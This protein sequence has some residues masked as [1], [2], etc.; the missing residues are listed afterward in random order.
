MSRKVVVVA[1]TAATVAAAVIIGRWMRRKE[2][3]RKQTQRI[4]RKFARECATPVSKLWTV[5][6]AMVADMAASLAATT[7]AE[8]RGSLNMLV[9][10]AG[11]LPS[12]DEKGLHYGANLRGKELLLLR[13]TLGG[14]EEPISDIYK[15]EISIPEDVL[16]G[17]FKEL[18]DFISLDLVKFLG[19]NPGEETEDV[20]NL[21]FTLTRYVE[22]IRSGSISAIHRKSLADGDDD[23]VLK[24]FVNDMNESLDRHGLKIRMNMAL[25]DDTIGILAGGRYYHKDTVAAVTL[26]MG[27][28]AAY[29]EQAQEVL[30]WKSTIPNEP[31]EIVI[32][33]EWGDFR[34]CHL[35]LTEFDAGLDAESLNPG[36]HVFEKM[37]SGGYL[38][39]IVRRVLLRM[40]EESALFGDILPPKLKTPYILGSPDMAAMHQDISEDRDIVNKKLKEVFGIMDS[41][42]AAREVVV[43]VCDVVAERAARV[44]GAGIV[45]MI[46]KLGR[47]EKKMSIVIVE[48]GL[49]DHYRVFRN[50]L[51]SSVWEMLG[52]ELSDHVVIEHSHGGSGAGALF[53]AACGNGQPLTLHLSLTVP[54]TTLPEREREIRRMA[55]A[56]I[57]SALSRA[58]ITAAPKTSLAPKRRFSSSAGLDD[59]CKLRTYP[60]MHIRNK[61]FP[62]GPDGLFEVK[63]NEGH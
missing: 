55:T 36:S 50:Y 35:P 44:A 7:A 41:T 16:N 39:D 23:K 56:I 60:Y 5:A 13:G 4:L 25:V 27:T 40:S 30:R 3:R 38:G 17:S 24:E 18:C 9:S 29:I 22:E 26:G 2:R 28:N 52:D 46:K 32:S 34:S 62:W 42:L 49:Y 59:A 45:G 57:R 1:A 20:K 33:T 61:E 6:D 53:F 43:E 8:S 47:L 12:G 63:H 51:H 10:F 14:N 58:A 11:S 21:G 37:V 31:Q 15:Q 54:F 19:M 48:G